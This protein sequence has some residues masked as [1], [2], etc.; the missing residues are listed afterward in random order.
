MEE[1]E[2]CFNYASKT[3]FFLFH[4]SH[5]CEQCPTRD[6][7]TVALLFS[8]EKRSADVAAQVNVSGI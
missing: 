7:I 5:Q 8:A 4:S 2:K 1:E 3:H 6:A